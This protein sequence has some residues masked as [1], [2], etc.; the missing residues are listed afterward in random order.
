M[1]FVL[2]RALK[3][4]IPLTSIDEVNDS[5]MSPLHSAAAGGH[6][7]CITVCVCVCVFM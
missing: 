1:V 3:L 5:G 4:L 6:T 2:F 7:D